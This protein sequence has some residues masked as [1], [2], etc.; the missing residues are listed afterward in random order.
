MING[1]SKV[2]QKLLRYFNGTAILTSFVF[3]AAGVFPLTLI[4][5]LNVS[6]SIILSFGASL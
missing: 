3:P 1:I 2:L 4:L 5:P 6:D